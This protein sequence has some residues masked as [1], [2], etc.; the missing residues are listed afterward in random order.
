MGSRLQGF[1]DF[2]LRGNVVDLAIAVVIGA[3]FTK[4]IGAVVDGFIAPLIGLFLWTGNLDKSL[5]L[6]VGEARFLFGSVL[7]AAITFALTAAVI[8]FLVI[9]P[10]RVLTERRRRGEEAPA[11]EAAVP[12]D[13]A[14]LTE[15][16]NL[17]QAQQGRGNDG[18]W[19]PTGR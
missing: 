14:L 7:A 1:K 19:G 16:R 8:Y 5:V 10:M 17:L 12:E 18:D 13:I 11:E 4:I 6:K 15:I 3:A 2:L 9:V